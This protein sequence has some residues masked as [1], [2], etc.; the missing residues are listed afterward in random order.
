VSKKIAVPASPEEEDTPF[1]D[2]SRYCFATSMNFAP[3]RRLVLADRLPQGIILAGRAGLGKKALALGLASLSFCREASACGRCAPCRQIIAGT[4]PH[5][6]VEPLDGDAKSVASIARVQQHLEIKVGRSKESPH[7]RRMALIFDAEQLSL[8]AANRLLKTL[9]EPPSPHSGIILTS[10]RPQALLATIRSRCIKW[11]ITAPSTAEL[12]SYLHRLQQES[13]GTWPALPAPAALEALCSRYGNTPAGLLTHLQGG[14]EGET[15]QISAFQELLISGQFTA[16]LSMLDK[17]K[18]E[19]SL[20][21]GEIAA[22]GEYALN[23][24]YKKLFLSSEE[25]SSAERRRH[26]S[27]LTIARR[28]ALLRTIKDL[29]TRQNIA[30]NAPLAAETLFYQGFFPDQD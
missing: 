4:H 28:R 9:E 17:I 3:W 8:A 10:S 19:K 27:P 12:L 18:Q 1:P 7:G 22:A 11:Q 29:A 6:F 13:P 5:V 25:I 15:D 16:M 23:S 21:A 24:G 20:S 26:R 30:L 14:G 2:W